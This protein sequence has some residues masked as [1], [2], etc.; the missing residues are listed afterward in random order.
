VSEQILGA[1]G[2]D[3]TID[4]TTIGARSGRPR[5][6]EIW[7]WK[8]DGKIYLTGSPG[9]RGWYANLKANPEFTYHLK[10]SAVAD[11]RA[12]ARPIEDP[13]EKRAILEPLLADYGRPD[14]LDAW[15]ARSP[16]AEVELLD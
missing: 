16:L 14:Y 7:A 5:R 9:W 3:R 2:R 1:L 11:L 8:L 6:I 15:V 10:E 13:A 12:H 4:I